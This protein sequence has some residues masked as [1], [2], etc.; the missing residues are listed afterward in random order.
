MWFIRTEVNCYFRP[1]LPW[2]LPEE[3]SALNFTTSKSH[4]QV[5]LCTTDKH[6]GS[7]LTTHRLYMLRAAKI[8]YCGFQL[9][10]F[11]IHSH[12]IPPQKYI[13]ELIKRKDFMYVKLQ[14]AANQC[15]YSKPC[16]GDAGKHPSA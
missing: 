5:P 12:S 10:L 15:H 11:L 2:R 13:K 7:P 8:Q 14:L 4:K 6:Y 9:Y 3:R 1:N 16:L